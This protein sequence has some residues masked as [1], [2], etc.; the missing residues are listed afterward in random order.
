MQAGSQGLVVFAYSYVDFLGAGSACPALTLN[1]CTC[2]V[3]VSE[4][5]LCEDILRQLRLFRARALSLGLTVHKD[6]GEGVSIRTDSLG[7]GGSR[8]LDDIYAEYRLPETRN[9]KPKP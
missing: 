7:G 4:V 9:P 1:P 6:R 5:R 2:Q 8:S 3:Q